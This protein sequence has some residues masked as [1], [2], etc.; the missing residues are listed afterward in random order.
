MTAGDMITPQ[1][2]RAAPARLHRNDRAVLE[3]LQATT[4]HPT[5]IELHEMVRQ[6]YP[7]IG[8]A[9]VYRALQRLAAAGFTQSVGRD[10]RGRHYDAHIARHDHAI[11]SECGRI[12]DLTTSNQS[13]ST[14]ALTQFYRAAEAVGLKAETWEMRIY[15]RCAE[16]RK[17]QDP[18]D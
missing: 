1:L 11:C 6:K 15:G 2:A 5:A 12:F 3:A 18:A 10:T 4:E 9:T 7:R 8:R 17:E 16:C 13:L 14:E